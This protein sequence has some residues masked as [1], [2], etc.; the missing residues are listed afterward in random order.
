MKQFKNMYTKFILGQLKIFG[1]LIIGFFIFPF[2]TYPKRREIWNMKDLLFKKWYWYYSDSSEIWG[3]EEQNYLNSTY[4]LYELVRKRDENGKWVA[5]YE[6]FETFGK[7]RKWFLSYHWL[8]F[9]NGVWNYISTTK[10]NTNDITN[11]ECV[12]LVG[13]ADCNVVRN[14]TIHGLQSLRWKAEGKPYFLYS[15]TKKVKWYN[16]QR[17]LTFFFNLFLLKIVWH[18]YYTFVWG[19]SIWNEKEKDNRFLVK[20]R[21]F[22]L[23]DI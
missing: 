14:K 16:I 13:N 12:K 23:E 8:V 1:M 11:M 22:N 19:A 7:L 17:F 2:I 20:T 10:P 9:R 4:G 18:K 15:F 21:T 3:T 6:K 5:D